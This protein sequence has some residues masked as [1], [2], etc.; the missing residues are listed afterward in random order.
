MAGDPSK[1]AVWANA[2]VYIGPLTATN[3]TG[4]AAFSDDWDAVG[5]LSGDDGFGE[6]IA[7]DSSDFF[8]WGGILVATTRKNFK[9]TRTF[10]AY[11]D[12]ATM[13]DLWWP[14]HDVTFGESGYEGDLYVPDLQAKFKIAFETRSGSQIKRVVSANYAQLDE[15]G[16]SKEGENDLASRAATVA[17]YPAAAD[18]DGKLKLFHTYR[19]AAES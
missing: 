15:R 19:G 16:E 14:G 7:T 10:T 9:L 11:E 5:L 17:I 4:G 18:S 1:A 12:N 2:D 6:Q 8:A 3:P 13:F